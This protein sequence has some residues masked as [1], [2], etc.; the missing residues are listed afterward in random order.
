MDLCMRSMRQL[1]IGSLVYGKL[2]KLCV[3]AYSLEKQ[4]R[5]ELIIRNTINIYS[6]FKRRIARLN[7]MPSTSLIIVTHH[8]LSMPE[9]EQV[10]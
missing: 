3:M 4:Q 5:L 2:K 7:M 10:R 8:G 9:Y 6:C 1:A